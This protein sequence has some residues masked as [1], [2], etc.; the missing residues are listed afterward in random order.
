MQKSYRKCVC[1]RNWYLG[2]LVQQCCLSLTLVS[3]LK[4][5]QF[6]SSIGITL[7]VHLNWLNWFR[8]FI[9][10]GGSL[11]ILIECMIFLTPFLEVIR[12]SILTVSFLA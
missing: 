5:S 11:V 12:M 1:Y 3:S 2:L 6:K 4:C 8:F 7:D 10:V 9:L